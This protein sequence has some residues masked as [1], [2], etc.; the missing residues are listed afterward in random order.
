MKK[1]AVERSIVWGYWLAFFTLVIIAF[2][3]Y[4]SSFQLRS[5]GLAVAHSNQVISTI[6]NL[7]LTTSEMESAARGFLLTPSPS[8]KNLVVSGEPYL[9]ATLND[10]ETMLKPNKDQIENLDLLQQKINHFARTCRTLISIREIQGF[11]TSQTYFVSSESARD[12]VEIKL[13]LNQMEQLESKQL[14]SRERMREELIES[15]NWLYISLLSS[16]FIVMMI[17]YYN[18]IKSIRKSDIA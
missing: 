14:R 12:L 13:L 6:S 11:E 9:L 3:S 2:F 17:L 18:I 15:F 5:S 16:V 1:V 8:L 10:L 7:N 4:Q